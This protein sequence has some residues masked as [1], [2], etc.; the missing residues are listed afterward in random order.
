VNGELISEGEDMSQQRGISRV[1][2]VPPPAPG[3]VG[4]GHLAAPVVSPENFEMNDPF[5]LLMDDHL[6]IGNRTVGGPHPHAGFETVTL[7]L[8]GAI[9]DRDEGGTLS[10]GEVQWMTAGSGI[11]HGEDVMT[12]GKV[13]LLQLWI[14][15]PKSER[16]T[17]PRFQAIHADSIPVRH[18][19]GAE[20][21]VY[22]GSSGGL[23]AGTGN[24]VP[25]TMV[26]INLEPHA[27]AE[28]EVPASYNGF[29]FVVDGSVQIGQ[30]VL[31]SSQVGWLDRP[32]DRGT[33]ALSLVAGESG[34]R[35]ILYAGQ[36]QRVPIVSYGPFV[37]D[38]KQDIARLFAEYRAGLFPRLSELRAQ[39]VSDAAATSLRSL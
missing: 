7:I 4:P 32:S 22:S 39:P 6:D 19:S 24:H 13:R 20:I 38:S 21:R 16:W 30:T 8:D 36:P 2:T 11:I 1:L 28:Q 5:I 35:V 10:A 12:K 3:F 27:S 18:Q 33:S 29:A 9:Y 14:T 23:Q 31:M 17:A 15:L 37:G 25:V 26:E 34:A